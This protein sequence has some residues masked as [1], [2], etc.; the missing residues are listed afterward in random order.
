AR[1]GRRGGSVLRQKDLADCGSIDVADAVVVLGFLVLLL[2]RHQSQRRFHAVGD[3]LELRR[4]A[5]LAPIVAAQLGFLLFGV[6]LEVAHV[7][8]ILLQEHLADD[9]LVGRFEV[10]FLVGVDDDERVGRVV[11]VVL[12]GVGILGRL[13]EKLILNL[14]HRPGV[15]SIFLIITLHG[16]GA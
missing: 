7:V 5:L 15:A 10:I 14:R 12:A 6:F 9:D 8:I 1:R 3:F 16:V 4:V 11:G 13:R 2:R